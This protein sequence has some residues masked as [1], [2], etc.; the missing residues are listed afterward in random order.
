E[1]AS[2]IPA[3]MR[4]WVRLIHSAVVAAVRNNL[5]NWAAAMSFY[6]LFAFFPTVLLAAS[7]LSAFHLRGLHDNLLATASS[8]LPGSAA[9]LVREQLQAL[10]QEHAS[11]LISFSTAVLVFSASQAFFELMAALSGTY[12][13]VETR[14][15]LRRFG[16]SLL[17]ALSAGVFTVLALTVIVLGKH[18]LEIIAGP[19]PAASLLLRLWPLLRWS[20]TVG[21]MMLAL[22]LLY[23]LAPSVPPPRSGR[24]AAAVAATCLWLAASAGLAAYFNRFS[25]YSVI[26]GSLGAVTALMMWFYLGALAILF[27]AELH[28]AWLRQR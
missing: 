9:K 25:K 12:E 15:Y 7:I 17:L 8:N 13:Q 6:F 5:L 14:P 22:L 18:L 20:A 3:G 21:F 10:M 2:G 16:L 11:A 19:L 24:M 4:S 28:Q 27:G 1:P 26:Y 23:R